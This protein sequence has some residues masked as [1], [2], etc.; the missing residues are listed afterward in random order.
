MGQGRGFREA[1]SSFIATVFPTDTLLGALKVMERHH[2]Q[3]V[4]VVGAGGSLVGV[5]H[6][7]QVLAGWQ[8]DPLAQVSDVMARVRKTHAVRSQKRRLA[9]L[10][11]KRGGGQ[12]LF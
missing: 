2:V 12:K 5:V 7:T 9:R 10:H 8:T 1:L 11:G 6:E 4:G 3:V